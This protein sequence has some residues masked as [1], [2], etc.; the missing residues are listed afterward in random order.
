MSALEATPD[1]PFDRRT[2]LSSTESAELSTVMAATRRRS[3]IVTKAIVDRVVAI[4]LLLILAPVLLAI[5]LTVRLSSPGPSIFCQ[6][7]VGR[8]GAPFVIFKFRTMVQDAERRLVDLVAPDQGP[9]LFKMENDPRITRIGRFL[10]R[11]SLDEFPQLINV[12]L[13]QMSLI[14]PRPA[15]PHEAEHY[16]EWSRRRLDVRPGMTGLWQVSGRSNL[17][18]EEAI[19]LDL[20]YVDGMSLRTDMMIVFRTLRVVA[21][22]H[23]A[24]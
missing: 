14:G 21:T 11:S 23:G 2:T 15:L 13:G 19:R 24:M 6:V 18:W 5:A 3:W 12:A 7:R 22:G 16:D 20:D 4:L 8:N 9:A 1:E 17:S 10:R